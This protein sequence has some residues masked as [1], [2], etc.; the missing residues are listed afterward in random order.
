MLNDAEATRVVEE[1]LARLPVTMRNAVYLM[2]GNAQ[3]DRGI[4]AMWGR[5][6]S[7]DDPLQAV[8]A[9][10]AVHPPAREKFEDAMSKVFRERT[11]E[12]DDYYPEVVIGG[13]INAAIYAMTRYKLGYP[14]PLIINYGRW[15]GQFAKPVGNAFYLN[16][17]NRPGSRLD[18]PG[19]PGPLN[20]I[21]NGVL[22]PSD[23][24]GSEYQTNDDLSF[25]IRLNLIMSEAVFMQT[26]VDDVEQVSVNRYRLYSGDTY[27]CQTSRIVYATGLG[28]PKDSSSFFDNVQTI[29]EFLR[30]MTAEFP[31]E[32]IKRA[33]VVGAKDSGNIA[34]EALLGQGPQS[35]GNVASLDFVERI[36]W[37]GQ[38]ATTACE[39]R[40]KTRSR[41][42]GISRYMPR[43]N[44]EYTRVFPKPRARDFIALSSAYD[45]TVLATGFREQ[46]VRGIANQYGPLT[47]VYDTPFSNRI[48]AARV[49]KKAIYVIGPASDIQPSR[50]ELQDAP[51]LQRIGENSAAI[52]R[53]AQR[54]ADFA[55]LESQAEYADFAA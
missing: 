17:R 28:R 22:Q 21:P 52:F 37:Y 34:V 7:F 6:E 42:E 32:G 9:G 43:G 53:Y 36:D 39:Y 14:A 5:S 8:L 31:L 4:A 25:L 54:T 47:P 12:P 44:G 55:A 33:A 27:L 2:V 19:R 30:D 13:G 40:Q 41:Y 49:G 24:S 10:I 11:V 26:Y 15:G 51:A 16:S 35:M 3:M 1:Q 45:L 23:I 38:E 18:L 50:K 20:L 29:D 46:V 48:I